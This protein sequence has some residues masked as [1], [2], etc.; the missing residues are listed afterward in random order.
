M[1]VFVLIPAF[2]EER[3][4]GK[5]VR[6]LLP[7]VDGVVVVDDGSTDTTSQGAK[8]AGAEVLLHKNNLGKGA[9][10]RTGFHHLMGKDCDAIITMD[11]D[12][13]H[14]W[15]EIPLFLEEAKKGEADIIV[16]SRMG[17]IKQMP[18]IR[19]CTNKATSL[20]TSLISHQKVRDSQSGYRLIR[21]RVL[22]DIRLAT[23]K[24][25]IESE[26][27]IK[28]GK[29]GYSVKEIPIKTI[30][31]ERGSSKIKPIRDT[32]RFIRLVFRSLRW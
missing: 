10:L 6:S 17:N 2:N 28:A 20:I 8:E 5:L 9:A 11:A 29:M 25:E 15:K 24:F 21:R 26:L 1:K 23:S 13:Q 30:Y 18:L 12:R 19:Q 22:E 4:I 14:D 3:T 31:Q 7:L 32:L 27:L 16:G